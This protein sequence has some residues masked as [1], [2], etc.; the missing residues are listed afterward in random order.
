MSAAALQWSV[1]PSSCRAERGTVVHAA[2]GRRAAYGELAAAA[3]AL[4]VPSAPK[5][6]PAAEFRLIGQPRKRLDA[7]ALVRGQAQYGLD[8]RVP[9]M[10]VAVIA[11][12]PYPGGKLRSFDAAKAKTL[13]GVREVLAVRSGLFRRR[14]CRGRGS[15]LGRH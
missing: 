10:R 12:C 4:P 11:R 7:A 15:H 1:E 2:S 13:P 14:R 8:V 3:S 6:K 5:L 9:G